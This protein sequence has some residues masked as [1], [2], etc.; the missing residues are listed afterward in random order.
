MIEQYQ[1]ILHSQM[2][3]RAGELTLRYEGTLVQGSLKLV[4]HLN[5]VQ[6]VRAG[7]GTLHLFHPIQTA[8]STF[9]CETVLGISGGQLTGETSAQPCRMRWEG[10][11]IPPGQGPCA[12]E[13]SK[14]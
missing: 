5:P 3:P 13:E 10:V 9:P 6:G 1:V 2:G 14:P 4:G 8:V 12:V 7:D 11:Q